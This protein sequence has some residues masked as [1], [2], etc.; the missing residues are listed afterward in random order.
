M[1]LN[2][3]RINQ[4]L[5]EIKMRSE[6]IKELLN[7]KS[8]EEILSSL[9]TIKGVKYTIV[10]IAEAM[11]NVIQHILSRQKGIPVKGYVEGIVVAAEEGIIS[12]ELSGKLKPFFDFRNSIIHRYWIISD[13]K[14]LQLLRE[15][16]SDFERFII[17]IESYIE[18]TSN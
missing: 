16:L 4:Y 9:W 10:E 14:L 18:K 13:K 11:A 12:K 2:L 6:Q 3:Q 15:N 7:E 1:K 17:E 5:S 8:D